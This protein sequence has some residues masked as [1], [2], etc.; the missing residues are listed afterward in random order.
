MADIGTAF[1]ETLNDTWKDGYQFGDITNTLFSPLTTVNKW[2]D[3]TGSEAAQKQYENQLKLDAQANAKLVR[4][5]FKK[6]IDKV[7]IEA[8]LSV[9]VQ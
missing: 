2:L 1:R 6:L 8:N 9:N 3:V 7:G 5:S 4:F